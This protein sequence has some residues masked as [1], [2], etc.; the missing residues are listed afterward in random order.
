MVIGALNR[1]EPKGRGL[2]TKVI[3]FESRRSNFQP[4]RAPRNLPNTRGGEREASSCRQWHA[5]THAREENRALCA[6]KKPRRIPTMVPVQ[7]PEAAP[8][9]FLPFPRSSR[10]VNELQGCKSESWLNCLL[11]RVSSRVLHPRR[12]FLPPFTAVCPRGVAAMFLRPPLPVHSPS[13]QSVRKRGREKQRKS[14]SP[15]VGGEIGTFLLYRFVSNFTR[16]RV[17]QR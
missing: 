6:C 13:P 11:S 1:G 10:P 15:L 5:H 16:D 14:P 2:F 7:C 8:S 17:R 4:V 12:L 9:P 3:P